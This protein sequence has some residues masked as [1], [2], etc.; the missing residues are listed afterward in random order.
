VS[1][2]RVE[3]GGAKRAAVF[4]DRDGTIIVDRHYL[5]DAEGV[6]LLPGAGQAIRDL[7]RAGLPVILV[8][9]QSGIGRGFFSSADFEAVQRRLVDLLNSHG[10]HLDAVYHCPHAP[11]HQP[12]CS[13]RKPEPGL[14]LRAARE[15]GIDLKASFFVGDRPR[16]VEAA[17]RF[18]ARAYLVGEEPVRGPDEPAEHPQHQLGVPRLGTLADAVAAIL[19]QRAAD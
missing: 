3:E 8:T 13:C 5:G 11:D 15:H 12:P 17:G 4:L 10:A 18:G 1:T 19:R 16:D 14:F 9:N 6:E 2:S 7:N